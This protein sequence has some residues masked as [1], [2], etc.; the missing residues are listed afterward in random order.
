MADAPLLGVA[1]DSLAVDAPADAL[2][3]AGTPGQSCWGTGGARPSLFVALGDRDLEG[4]V[5]ALQ[6]QGMASGLKTLEVRSQAGLGDRGASAIALGLLADPA[7]CLEHLDLTGCEVGGPG[8]VALCEA[9]AAN[10]ATC[11]RSL[12]LGW[13]PLGR[14]GGL[15]VAHL[16]G[17]NRT[18]E[19]LGLC[20]TSLDTMATVCLY[21]ALRENSVHKRATL[22]RRVG[23]RR[24]RRGGG[25]S[26]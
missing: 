25:A 24:R 14:E 19:V 21:A 5:E 6:V 11:L 2:A 13:N 22:R 8:V 17:A 1:L 7:C 15:A 26:V 4:L 12:R 18:I 9:V 23:R 3:I 16:M 10:P 20:N